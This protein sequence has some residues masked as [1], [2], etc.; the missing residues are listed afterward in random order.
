MK[1]TIYYIVGPQGSG[2]TDWAEQLTYWEDK[3]LNKPEDSPCSIM[4]HINKKL[5]DEKL[6]EAIKG[7]PE[8]YAFSS[9][10]YLAAADTKVKKLA[11]KLGFEYIKIIIEGKK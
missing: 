8:G 6:Q 1:N 11:A 10:T 4:Q 2:K 9:S 7:R 5:G 3:S